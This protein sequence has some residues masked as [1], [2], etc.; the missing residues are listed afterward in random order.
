MIAKIAPVSREM[1][2]NYIAERVLHLPKSYWGR[3]YSFSRKG[4]RGADPISDLATGASAS[5]SFRHRGGW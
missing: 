5:R 2:L 4:R 1:I 3:P